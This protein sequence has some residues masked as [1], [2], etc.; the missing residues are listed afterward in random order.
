MAQQEMY[1]AWLNDAYGMEQS[2]IPVLENHAK[3]AKDH[4]AMAQKISQHL[5][6]TKQHGQLVKG[7]IERNGG[8]TSSIKSGISNL[9][10]ML[11][12]VATGG[13]KDEL[14]KDGLM[15]F[16]AENFEIASYKGLITAAQTL[17]DTETARI[18]QQIMGQEQDMAAFLDQHLGMAVQET[19]QK[20]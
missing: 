16:A 8:H 9:M 17:G 15:D 19:L 6:Q 13:A 18:C 14:V 10:G 4:P 5:E 2:L 11:Q 12:S 20:A 7:C 1:L 3:D